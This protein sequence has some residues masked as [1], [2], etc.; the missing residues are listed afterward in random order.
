MKSLVREI[1]MNLR[2]YLPWR[3]WLF[4]LSLGSR[5]NNKMFSLF[6]PLHFVRCC[7]RFSSHSLSFSFISLFHSVLVS[8]ESSPSSPPSFHT[9]LPSLSFASRKALEGLFSS[10]SKISGRG[11]Y[12]WKPFFIHSSLFLCIRFIIVAELIILKGNSVVAH[13]LFR[14]SVFHS[15][16]YCFP[17]RPAVI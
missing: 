15:L 12:I 11:V 9:S 8:P 5:Y 16:R 4:R 10:N 14:S 3:V 2:K 1:L 6:H 7:S 13:S 17:A